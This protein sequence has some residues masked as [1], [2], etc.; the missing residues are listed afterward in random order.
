MNRIPKIVSLP[1]LLI[2]AVTV[3]RGGPAFL[4]NPGLEQGAPEDARLPLGFPDHLLRLDL[5]FDRSASAARSGDYGMAFDLEGDRVFMPWR[6]LDV[7]IGQIYRFACWYRTETP[8][9]RSRVL[10]IIGDG[11]TG[12]RTVHYPTVPE[13]TRAEVFFCGE[14]GERN[15]YIAVVVRG[16][17]KKTEN[18]GK[19]PGKIPGERRLC[20]DDFTFGTASS[21]DYAR[22]NLVQ[23]GGF[24]HTQQTAPGWTGRPAAI[25]VEETEPHSGV[26][27]GR[28]DA[29][30]GKRTVV[31][32]G[33]IPLKAGAIYYLAY[34]L[35]ASETVKG[36]MGLAVESSAGDWMHRLTLTDRWQ[37]F[38]F[39]LEMPTEE[40]DLRKRYHGREWAYRKTYMGERFVGGLV[41]RTTDPGTVWFDDVVMTMISDK[42]PLDD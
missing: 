29:V 38:R 32:S 26:R 3:A 36:T 1:F 15:P 37:V 31:R 16:G 40:N 30:P 4:D 22:E 42:P 18:D 14:E 27:C 19:K 25:R 24:E 13:W 35:R 7:E 28:A 12:N 20:V 33:R 21:A 34:A 39:I 6:G 10:E 2:L 9:P 41:F 5:R 23:N 11:G 8:D 17:D